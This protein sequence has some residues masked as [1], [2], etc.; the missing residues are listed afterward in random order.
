MIRD[1]YLDDVVFTDYHG[2]SYR[3]KDI[4]PF[5]DYV[6]SK[7]INISGADD[8]D[9]IASREEIY[10]R[11]GESLAYAIIDFNKEKLFDAKYDMTKLRT[12]DIPVV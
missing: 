11:D 8:I 12:L 7:T 3:I 6:F 2:R 5:P 4:R 1:Y 9:E 10:G